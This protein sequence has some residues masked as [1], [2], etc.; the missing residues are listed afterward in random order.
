MCSF[1]PQ[2]E[3][4]LKDAMRVY[5]QDVVQRFRIVEST[6]TYPLEEIL[7][8]LRHV[9]VYVCVFSSIWTSH[10][11]VQFRHHG[12]ERVRVHR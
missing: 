2:E 10:S 7:Q 11:T 4:V 6:P 12:V 5:V 9:V 3:N 8:I 1:Q